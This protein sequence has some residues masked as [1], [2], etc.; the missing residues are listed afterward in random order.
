MLCTSSRMLDRRSLYERSNL[1]VLA[2]SSTI[3]DTS[4]LKD[5]ERNDRKNNVRTTFVLR[6]RTIGSGWVGMSDSLLE[7]QVFLNCNE[8]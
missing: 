7:M 4:S 1:H 8:L 3:A 2:R 5:R 6:T